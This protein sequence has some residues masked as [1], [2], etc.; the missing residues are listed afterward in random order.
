MRAAFTRERDH[1]TMPT[2]LKGIR[3]NSVG[4]TRLEKAYHGDGPPRQHYASGGAVK[5][6]HK[7]LGGGLVGGAAPDATGSPAKKSL[8]HKGRK[9]KGQ[10]AGVGNPKVTVINMPPQHP[11][12]PGGP[13]MAGIRPPVPP[14]P[15]PGAA[16]PA[17]PPPVGPMAGAPP[18]PR[19][20]GGPPTL[21]AKF[22]GR[23]RSL[24][25]RGG[26]VHDKHD[27]H[28]DHDHDGDYK[29]GGVVGK[30]KGVGHEIHG[31]ADSKGAPRQHFANKGFLHGDQKTNTSTAATNKDTPKGGT[32]DVT[33]G[34][35][36]KFSYKWQTSNAHEDSPA[37]PAPKHRIADHS[38]LKEDQGTDTTNNKLYA[39]GGKVHHGHHEHHG[40]GPHHHH[41]TSS[42]HKGH[43]GHHGHHHADHDGGKHHV[44]HHSKGHHV[45]VHHHHHKK[46]G[47]VHKH[48]GG[49]VHHELTGGGVKDAST[50][51]DHFDVLKEKHGG[52]VKGHHK[53]HRAHKKYGGPAD[54]K[55]SSHHDG[56]PA[57]YPGT[58]KNQPNQEWHDGVLEAKHEDGHEED[59]HLHEKHGGVA[60]HHFAQ[61]GRIPPGAGLHV[62]EGGS[63]S[64]PGR[65]AKIKHWGK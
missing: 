45:E 27:E 51:G 62:D 46:G 64:G 65:D 16:G 33:K 9:A 29:H 40:D 55:M 23:I 13:M 34:P 37:P 53:H 54:G 2:W 49:K 36:N 35:Y 42:H 63:G 4:N 6:I 43:D 8:G 15:P 61:G 26:R 50:E 22:G 38:D 14:M 59:V 32:K 56:Y 24:F 57:K 18:I 48:A 10:G 21:G 20:G 7:Y 41:H 39:H 30:P 19:P 17:P 11:P 44:S 28:H 52:D 58:A 12:M 31:Q 47:K 5:R 3:P 25:K 60:H 1:T